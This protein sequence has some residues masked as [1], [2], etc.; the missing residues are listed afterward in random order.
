MRGRAGMM[1]PIHNI[2]VDRQTSAI[3][4]DDSR[5]E[6]IRGRSEIEHLGDQRRIPVE[7]RISQRIPQFRREPV[8]A[9]ELPF[10]PGQYD[11]RRTGPDRD[12]RKEGPNPLQSRIKNLAKRRVCR[13]GICQARLDYGR[14]RVEALERVPIG[15]NHPIDK[16][17]LNIKE[18]EHVLVRKVSQLFRNML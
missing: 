6:D 17:S 3:I 2:S 15:W 1:G 8:E 7:S 13:G 14:A 11:L 16:N 18:L 10:E 12:L 4:L 5:R 9:I